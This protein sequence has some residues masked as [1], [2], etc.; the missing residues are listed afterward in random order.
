LFLFIMAESER[1][2]LSV[3]FPLRLVSSEVP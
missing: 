3:E 1:F 2:E